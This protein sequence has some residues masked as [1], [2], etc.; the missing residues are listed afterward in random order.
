[1]MRRFSTTARFVARVTRD[2]G[3]TT[4]PI[5]QLS[6]REFR[7]FRFVRFDCA[8]DRVRR[9]QR[10]HR[11]F[12]L[13]LFPSL[14]VRRRLWRRHPVRSVR[15]RMNLSLFFPNLRH[16]RLHRYFRSPIFAQ[17]TDFAVVLQF[18]QFFARKNVP[19]QSNNFYQNS[20]LFPMK[21]R[22]CWRII[23]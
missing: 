20:F 18:P 6:W 23:N 22:N 8:A 3:V 16:H 12:S 2:D 13:R 9:S 5:P 19:E 14:V 10:M 15:D 11:S 4:P 17:R 7:D 1:M 21:L